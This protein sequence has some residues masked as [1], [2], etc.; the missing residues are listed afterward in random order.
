M[1]ASKPDRRCSGCGREVARLLRVDPPTCQRC[2]AR[3]RYRAGVSRAEVMAAHDEA[4][5]EEALRRAA[6]HTDKVNQGIA[7][8]LRT[9]GPV[10]GQ[11]WRSRAAC[12]GQTEIFFQSDTTQAAEVCK[13]C[14]VLAECRTWAL[15]DTAQRGYAG[16]LRE[17]ERVD[18]R[19]RSA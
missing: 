16:G 10:L 3:D 12:K 13:V 2:Y 6:R 7:K 18:L 11:A 14:P 5:H 15:E 9:L 17:A 8:T 1:A 19:R 4:L